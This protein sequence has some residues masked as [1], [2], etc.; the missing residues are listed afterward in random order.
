MPHTKRPAATRT[1][2]RRSTRTTRRKAP[3]EPRLSRLRRPEQL[4]VE[5]WQAQLRRQFG[6]EQPFLIDNLGAE[7]VFS[8]FA[9]ANPQSGGRYRVA[10]RGAAAGENYCSCPDFA[11]NDLGTCKHVEFTLARLEARRGGKAALKRGF[12]PP[13]SEIYL[14][15]AGARS[16]RFRAG[17][18]CPAALARRA[19]AL[20]DA[21]WTLPQSRFAQFDVFLA[22]AQKSGHELRCYDDALAFIAAARDAESRNRVLDAAYPRGPRIRGL[23]KLLKTKLYPYQIDGALFAVRAGRCLIGDEMGLGKTIQA[24]AAA[25]LF[26]RHF[27][28]E[29]VLVVCPTSLKHQW[30]REFARFTGRDAQVIQGPRGAREQQ[31]RETVS[32]KIANYETLARDLDLIGAW[33]PD[34]VIVDE[35]QRI[36]NWNTIAA[37]ALKRIASPYAVVLTGTPLENRLEELVSIVQFVDQYRL[38]PTWRLLHEHQMRDEAGRVVGYR[39]LDRLGATL[40]PVMLRRRKAEVLDQLPERVDNTFFVPM[41]PQQLLHHDENADTVARIVKRWRRTGHLSET[42]QRVLTCAL[43]N[44]RMSC[45]STYLLDH[46]TDHGTKVDELATLLGELFERPEAKAV[47]F[48][49]WVRTHELIIR[50]LEAA[51]FGYVLFHGGVPAAKRGGLVER[52]HRDPE[53]RVFLSTD[54]GGVGLNLQHAASTVINMDLPWNPAVLE[55][56]IGRV[57]RMGQT[58]SVQVVNFVAQGTIEEGMLSVLAFKKSLFAGVLD[59]GANEVFLHGTR[60]ARF[61]QSVDQVTGKM[62]EPEPAVDTAP[63]AEAA[64]PEQPVP[65]EPVAPAEVAAAGGVPEPS[66]APDPWATLID[67]GL[68]LVESLAAPRSAEGRAA[69]AAPESWLETDAQTGRTYVK[70]PAPAPETL[71]RLAGALATLLAGLR[72]R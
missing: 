28:T 32:W 10:I 56:R 29:R 41:T 3:A 69:H 22:A 62:G 38:G 2:T 44:M 49:Q 45:N 53:C 14:N 31:Y 8:E 15:Y 16:V 30:Q 39:N 12:T 42:D 43:Q 54:A 35:A 23:A 6:R 57:H 60:L 55:Q 66:T 61:M 70:L 9:V 33:S 13:Y 1:S 20:F 40:A 59:G 19:A 18:D 64:L 11:T 17:A 36:K 72:P 71:Q 5:A 51:R 34:V 50:R 52:F 26:A 65:A 47:I 46:E 37:R 67:A 27:G 48:S 21:E 58:S 7:P 4:S 68:K 25:E 63:A 24:I